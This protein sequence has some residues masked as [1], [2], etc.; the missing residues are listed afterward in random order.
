MYAQGTLVKIVANP[1]AVWFGAFKR[2]NQGVDKTYVICSEPRH[3]RWLGQIVQ[4]AATLTNKGKRS[5]WT[6]TFCLNEIGP[7]LPEDIDLNRFM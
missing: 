6:Y 3:D 1:R 2:F 7:A 4:E 5:S